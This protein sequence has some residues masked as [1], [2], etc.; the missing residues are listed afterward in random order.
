MILMHKCEMF[1]GIY[2]FI[3][4]FIVFFRHRALMKEKF[5]LYSN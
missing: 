4:F 1:T 2:F 3:V 5:Q